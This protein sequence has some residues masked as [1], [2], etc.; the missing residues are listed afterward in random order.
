[1]HPAPSSKVCVAARRQSSHAGAPRREPQRRARLL[2]L[3]GVLGMDRYTADPANRAIII[4]AAVD[5]FQSAIATDPENA[6]AK[7]NL[8]LVLRDFFAP[9]MPPA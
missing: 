2:N 8:E 6:D 5:T 7:F 4:R 1:M 3:L 9:A